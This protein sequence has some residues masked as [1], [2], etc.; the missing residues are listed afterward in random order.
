MRTPSATA[1]E[2]L[3]KYFKKVGGRPSATAEKK[4]K[5]R[6]KDDVDTP[7]GGR[8]KTKTESPAPTNGK[9]A[10][11]EQEW[12]PPSGS[13]ETHLMN[14]DTIEETRDLKTNQLERYAYVVW[15]DGRKTRHKLATLNAQAPQIVCTLLL[16][17]IVDC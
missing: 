17:I 9:K 5:K 13:W 12:R 1:K 11:K 3:D 6:K 7:K 14:I 4:S 15:N 8:K 2:S 16:F 10:G